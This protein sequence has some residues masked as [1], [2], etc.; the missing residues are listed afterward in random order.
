MTDTFDTDTDDQQDAGVLDPKI[1]EELRQARADRKALKEMKDELDAQKRESAGAKA[2]LPDTPGAKFFLQHYSGPMD[3]ES[4][5]NAAQEMGFLTPPEP[6]QD[7][8]AAAEL[9]ALRRAQSGVRESGEP[10][11][12]A[13]QEYYTQVDKLK[14]SWAPGK[15]AELVDGVS[16]AIEEAQRRGLD[17][18]LA[19]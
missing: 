4:I 9:A 16:A 5:K 14:R 8:D 12:E 19:R 6:P 17:V 2:G 15:E 1:R 7:D 3:A 10:E 13:A 18:R 11:P